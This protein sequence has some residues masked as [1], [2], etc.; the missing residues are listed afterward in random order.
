MGYLK[1]DDENLEAFDVEG[2]FHTGDLGFLDE[3]G[4]L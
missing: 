3:F 1:R 2:Y 4:R